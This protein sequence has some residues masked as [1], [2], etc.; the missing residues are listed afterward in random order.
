M[1]RIEPSEHLLAAVARLDG[2]A[3]AGSHPQDV[4]A[5]AELIAV[6]W[7][8]AARGDLEPDRLVLLVQ[9]LRRWCATTA[10]TYAV[11]WRHLHRAGRPNQ[12][13]DARRWAVALDHAQRALHLY[14]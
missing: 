1:K 6:D 14:D 4:A 8:W 13:E 2:M 3:L 7:W 10:E 5:A 12:A 11:R 9:E